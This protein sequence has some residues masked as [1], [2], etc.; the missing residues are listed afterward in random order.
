MVR[1]LLKSPSALCSLDREF[2]TYIRNPRGWIAAA[3]TIAIPMARAWRVVH[4]V[5]TRPRVRRLPYA[6]AVRLLWASILLPKML[7]IAA[8]RR[9]APPSMFSTATHPPLGEPVR[10]LDGTDSEWD[11]YRSFN[12]A[13]GFQR[14]FKI[15]G[16]ARGTLF[17]D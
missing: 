11:D 14:K 13:L 1:V 6:G 5:V 17:D 8:H 16:L 7:H 15:A 9:L 12:G 3:C 2:V 10:R 4:S